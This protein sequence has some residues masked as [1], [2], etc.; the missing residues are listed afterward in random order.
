MASR[1]LPPSADLFVS[2]GKL[3]A[4]RLAFQPAGESLQRLDWVL[5]QTQSGQRAGAGQ[6][7]S[8]FN[9]QCH[10]YSTG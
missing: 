1:F 10:G 2:T 9:R 3:S 7:E 4:Y 8:G 5:A 6:F